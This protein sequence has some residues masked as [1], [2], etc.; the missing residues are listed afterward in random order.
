[1]YHSPSREAR[2]LRRFTGLIITFSA[3]IIGVSIVT[4]FTL[5]YGLNEKD[6][7]IERGGILQLGST[8]SNA[9]VTINNVPFS[10]RT[11]TRLVSYEGDYAI[12]MELPNYKTWQKTVSIQPGVITWQTYARLFPNEINPI[13]IA[14]FKTM[15]SA[16]P[17]GSGKNYAL[18]EK[19]NQA[20]VT[21]APLDVDD[22]KTKSI[23]LPQDVA[24]QPEK[25]GEH[26]TYKL[27]LWN[28]KEDYILIKHIYGNDKKT[29]WLVLDVDN[30]EDSIN[31]SKSYGIDASEVVFSS[32]NG[33]QIVALIDGAVRQIDLDAQTLSRPFASNV[34]NF[35]LYGDEYI[36]YVTNP[37]AD[38]TQ[39]VGYVRKEF[40][41]PFVIQKVPY[42][43]STTALLDFGKYFDKYY[44]LISHANK[45]TLYEM[46]DFYGSE[47]DTLDLRT[48]TDMNL[49][50]PIKTLDI[51]DNSQFATIQDGFSFANYN[52]EL[53]QQA[54]TNIETTLNQPQKL[55]HL[56][57]YLYWGTE[58]GYLRTYEYDGANQNRLMAMDPAF[59]ATFSPSGKYLYSVVVKDGKYNLQ[60]IQILGL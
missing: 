10:S 14:S 58:D 53:N 16:L 28:G 20:V 31:L 2:L 17:S 34:N 19:A 36:L 3:V 29:E 37:L 4:A 15:A 22:V 21:I 12:K 54:T 60:R 7:R 18:L 5:G 13:N 38:K 8:P 52:L 41:K 45:A 26:N 23:T 32:Y 47:K 43:G 39:E 6:G 49:K 42:D 50:K 48:V 59:E 9:T 56:D 1:M 51:T 25:S 46:K 44:A 40:K 24:T 30:P 35:R 11:P 57:T 27:M 55:R 33:R